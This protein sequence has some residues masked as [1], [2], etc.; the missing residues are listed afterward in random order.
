MQIAVKAIQH[1]GLKAGVNFIS[2]KSDQIDFNNSFGFGGGFASL[3][4][5]EKD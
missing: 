2:M 3:W 4:V 5:Q 1:P